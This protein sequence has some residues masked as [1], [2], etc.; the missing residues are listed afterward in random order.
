MFQKLEEKIEEYLKNH[1]GVYKHINNGHVYFLCVK[2]QN[3][4]KLLG[5][6]FCKKGTS[7]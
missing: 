6:L 2:G 7:Y 1:P 5:I 3:S 4:N